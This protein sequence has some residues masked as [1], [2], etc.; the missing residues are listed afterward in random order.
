MFELIPKT[1]HYDFVGKS[2]FFSKLS[3]TAVLLA[4]VSLFA[5]GPR[6]SIDF[7]GGTEVELH[8]E[9][10]TTIGEIRTA[11][12]A[13][14]ISED[15]IQQV[16]ALD[17][18]RFLVRVQGEASA[19]PEDIAA[20]RAAF[21]AAKGPD[22]MTDFREDAQ[23]GT[24]ATVT[25]SG[26]PVSVAELQNAVAAL[27]GVSVQGASDEN[28]FYVRLP[29]IAE[30]VKAALAQELPD[31]P[32][33]VDRAD[34]VGPKVGGSMRTAGITSVVVSMALCLLYIA[35]RF[36][37]TFAPGAIVCLVH[38]V[39]ITIGI[40]VIAR[41]DFGLSTVS[42]ILTLVGYSL[43]DTIV[44]YDRIRENME[45]YRRKAFGELINDS[46]NQT[47]SRTLITSA[48]TALA[49][50]P[51]LFWG[52]PVLREFAVVLLLGMVSG[53]YSTIFVASPVTM[54]LHDNQES[55]RRLL[56]LG[57]A[58]AA[59]ASDTVGTKGK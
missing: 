50:V 16:G 8:Y 28:T 22:W 10:A 19:A 38:D 25:Y 30:R 9:A 15:S 34:S 35:V 2:R 4:I 37:F 57:R 27:R 43:N 13:I 23:V 31:R 1:F 51:F 52:G 48:A 26:P 5:L 58:P 39:L 21:A 49:M 6:W 12:E 45:H 53:V 20:V 14:D 47:L 24:R 7:T 59:K 36:D 41:F 17:Q 42:A 18:N 55:I 40:L 46:I 56:G 32:F 44:V 33:M 54:L 29:G 3:I 11:L